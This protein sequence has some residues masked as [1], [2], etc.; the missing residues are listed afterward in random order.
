MSTGNSLVV[1]WLGLHAFTAKGAGSPSPLLIATGE[2]IPLRG[3][4]G[5]PGLPGTRQDEAGITRKFAPS[6]GFSRQEYWSGVPLQGSLV[7]CCL[8]GHTESD[9]TEVT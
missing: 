6:M 1:Q 8:W 7:G 9:T 3:L 2:A 4:E 5:V